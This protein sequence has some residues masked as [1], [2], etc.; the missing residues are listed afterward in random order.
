MFQ[1]SLLKCFSTAKKV[2]KSWD[3]AG[4]KGSAARGK[5]GV[6]YHML[7][8]VHSHPRCASSWIGNNELNCHMIVTLCGALFQPAFPRG[9]NWAHGYSWSCLM[10]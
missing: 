1:F 6:P 7:E 2:Y 4:S 9:P 10:T 5:E 3:I 8:L